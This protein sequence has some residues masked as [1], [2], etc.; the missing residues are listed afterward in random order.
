MKNYNSIFL[1]SY[2]FCSYYLRILCLDPKPYYVYILIFI[3]CMSRK[4]VIKKK[5]KY[6]I[7]SI[8]AMIKINLDVDKLVLKSKNL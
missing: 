8:L 6:L 7:N 2:L 3:C 4:K 5:N 1:R